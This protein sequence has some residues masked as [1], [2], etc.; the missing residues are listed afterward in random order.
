MLCWSLRL[1]KA[2][3][4]LPPSFRGVRVSAVGLEVAG[5]SGLNRLLFDVSAVDTVLS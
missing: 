3:A 2:R 1:A 5:F 4:A